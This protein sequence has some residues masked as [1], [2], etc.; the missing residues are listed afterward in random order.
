M[1][2]STIRATGLAARAALD[3]EARRLASASACRHALTV[4]PRSAKTVAAYAAIRDEIDPRVLLE[5]LELRGIALA[6]PVVVAPGKPL[7]FRKYQIKDQLT[8]GPM[9][10]PQPSA[11]MPTIEPDVVIVP[12]VAFDR[13]G[14]RMGYGAGYYDRSLAF[15]KTKRSI[16]TIGFGFSVQEVAAVPVEP[17]DQSL[18]VIVTEKGPVFATGDLAGKRA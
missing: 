13:A 1:D 3:P 10:V 11:S 4:M 5:L 16:T 6:L 17:H 2:K 14:R 7:M 12:L 18:D 8:P 15:L 9:G